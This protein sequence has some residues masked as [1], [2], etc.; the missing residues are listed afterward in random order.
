MHISAW[1]GWARTQLGEYKGEH[2]SPQAWFWCLHWYA[3][4]PFLLL[5]QSVHLSTMIMKI[6]LIFGGHNF[7]FFVQIHRSSMQMLWFKCY[8]PSWSQMT[9]KE[10]SCA[11]AWWWGRVWNTSSQYI[12]LM[13]GQPLT[14][15]LVVA[16]S[17][18]LTQALSSFMDQILT[19][20]YDA[21]W[22]YM[23]IEFEQSL[24]HLSHCIKHSKVFFFVSESTWLHRGFICQ[25]K[26]PSA[27]YMQTFCHLTKKTFHAVSWGRPAPLGLP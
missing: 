24:S 22:F 4:M 3:W 19:M 14:G 6:R 27:D 10:R 13:K 23:V 2:Y 21:T 5:V 15:F 7:G 25:L 12:S 8:Q 1:H 17:H 18:A 16:S 26:D 11:C 9:M 20:R